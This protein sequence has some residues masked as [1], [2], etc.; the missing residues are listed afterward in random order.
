MPSA[1]KCKRSLNR[2]T[3][4][5][6]TYMTKT[7]CAEHKRRDTLFKCLL[8]FFGLMCAF[9]MLMCS[10]VYVKK[11]GNTYIFDAHVWRLRRHT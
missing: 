3:T 1:Q 7:C 8:F 11:T 5:C 6:S 4:A 10:L 9:S 2:E